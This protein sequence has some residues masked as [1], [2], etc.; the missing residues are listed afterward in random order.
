M[1]NY[2]F[3]R[4]TP[5]FAMEQGRLLAEALPWL[6]DCAGKT[7]VI[8]YGGAAMVD[9]TLQRQV[10]DDVVLLKLLGIK[11]ILVHGGG[12]AVSTAM[13]AQGLAVE[14]RD[15]LRVTTP[16][17]MEVVRD[18][19][20]GKVNSE[21]VSAMNKHGALA[22]GLSGMDANTMVGKPLSDEL[23]KT[24]MVTSVNADYLHKLLDD[25]YIPVLSSVA[26]DGCG[27]CLNVNADVVAGEVACAI[28]AHK[29]VFLTDVDGIYEDIND[30]SSFIAH[31]TLAEARAR[32][33]GDGLTKGM[34]P[35]L[36]SI[37]RALEGGVPRAHVIN[38]TVEHS[39]L[40]EILTDHGIGTMI[41][42][43]DE[44]KPSGF[45]TAPLQG[46]A[47]HLS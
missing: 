43:G 11:P 37:V 2:A 8:K 5:R 19:L 42:R 17:A 7:L 44:E 25:D 9:A 40:I 41:S 45:T 10:I 13:R 31:M 14:F 34:L 29:L 21:I 15:G 24:G 23:G 39:L 1:T 20:V 33:E 26:S 27:A 6:K 47:T 35:K 28:G 30:K 32:L 22:V 16:E 38:G 4:R 46:I 3:E 18:V 36:S 12:N